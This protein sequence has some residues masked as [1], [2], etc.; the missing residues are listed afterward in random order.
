MAGGAQGEGVGILRALDLEQRRHRYKAGRRPPGPFAGELGAL[1]SQPA[2][3]RTP[4]WLADG[5]VL[6]REYRP[7]AG[8]PRPLLLARWVMAPLRWR[9]FASL[10]ARVRI[11]FQRAC[12]APLALARRPAAVPMTGGDPAGYLD[13]EGSYGSLA[14]YAAIHPVTGDQIVTTDPREAFELDYE[15]PTLLGHLGAIAPVTGRLGPVAVPIPW[16]SRLGQPPSGDSS[17]L[18]APDGNIDYPVRGDVVDREAFFVSGWALLPSGPPVRVEL[19]ADGAVVA[20]ARL[21]IDRLDLVGRSRVAGAPIAGFEHMMV[22]SELPEGA[23]RLA[24]AAVAYGAEGER[25]RLPPVKVHLQRRQAAARQPGPVDGRVERPAR[26]RSAKL[27]LLVFMHNLGLGGSQLYLLETLER[28]LKENGLAATVAAPSDGPLREQFE[29]LGVDV[30]ISPAPKVNDAAAYERR[31]NELVAWAEGEGFD[32]AMVNSFLAFQGADV[33]ARLHL[34]Y[35]FAIH[36]SE[37]LASF[38]AN[39]QAAPEVR[40]RAEKGLAGASVAVFEAEA[41]R[42]R[43][44]SQI[45]AERA[46]TI[47]YGI[48]LGE[49][50]RFREGFDRIAARRRLGIPPKARLVLCLGTVEPRKAQTSL[51]HAFGAVAPSHPDAM[52]AVVGCSDQGWNTEYNEALGQ[53]VARSGLEPQVML[54]ELTE[55]PYEWHG[56]A[57]LLV[58]SSDIESLPRVV[59]EAMAFETPVLAT[60]IFGLPEMIEDGETG[61]LCAERDP[62]AL[63]GTL[64]RILSADPGELRRVGRAGSERVRERHD[65]QRRAAELGS[66]IDQ[67]VELPG[68]SRPKTLAGRTS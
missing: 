64:D 8:R 42:L 12:Q 13:R 37:S 14:L 48:E 7:R 58:C 67:L 4:V 38:W 18:S 29:A 46:I 28:I 52:L 27:R 36:E 49:V 33:A 60:A 63:G 3:G 6:T 21:G 1:R 34:P 9:G 23:E 56:A 45:E 22:E 32:V 25:H 5:W 62:V 31:T 57:D 61:Y 66:I 24:L 30:H 44:L 17:P 65:P 53:Y 19:L 26:A 39:L 55:Q 43:Y 47:P 59:L 10:P 40:E 50:D 16:A 54:A 2:P 41:T 68:G 51:V 11:L 15:D 20:R 35:V